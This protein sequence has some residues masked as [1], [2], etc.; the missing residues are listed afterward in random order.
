M[1]YTHSVRFLAMA[2]TFS[3]VVATALRNVETSHKTVEVS[4]S[5]GAVARATI[6]RSEAEPGRKSNSSLVEHNQ[7]N[8]SGQDPL[9][10]NPITFGAAA[11]STSIVPSEDAATTTAIVASGVTKKTRAARE[12]IG[13]VGEADFQQGGLEVNPHQLNQDSALTSIIPSDDGPT[14]TA[15][16]SFGDIPTTIAPS[17]LLDLQDSEEVFQTRLASA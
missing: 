5:H 10:L 6:V 13:T 15:I 8:A 12:D 2:C 1:H 9:E 11:T 14:T 3:S 16:V 17:S 4:V 7:Q